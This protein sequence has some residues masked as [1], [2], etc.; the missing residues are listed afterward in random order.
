MASSREP[1]PETLSVVFS[2]PSAKSCAELSLVLEA[3]SIASRQERIGDVWV[4]SVPAS[5]K[6]A[7]LAELAAYRGENAKP[8]PARVAEPIFSG[9]WP[10]LLAFA[11]VLL[12]IAACARELALGFDWLALGR[13]DAGRVVAGEWWRVVTA[14]TLHREA[15]H[16]LGN[17]GFGAFFAFFV[18][19]SWGGGLGWLGIVLAGALGNAVNAIVAPPEHLSIGASTAVFGALGIL[20]AHTWR[21]GFPAGSSFKE[22]LA[23]V[24]A[25]VGLLVFI[26]TAGENTDLGAHLFGF[27]AGFSG[28]AWIA[29]GPIPTSPRLQRLCAAG[30]WTLVVGAWVWGL[31]AA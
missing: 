20:S 6:P 25:G 26:G 4:L 28:A 23:P 5:A 30:A 1:D 21:R 11:G 27:A 12:L 10:S 8:G 19:R 17:I 22:R 15:G 14:L 13:M 16:L 9:S 7:A 2:S 24:V 3:R 29:R 18:C 31:L